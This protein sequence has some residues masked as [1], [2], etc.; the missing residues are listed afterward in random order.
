MWLGK[1]DKIIFEMNHRME[2]RMGYDKN[3]MERV[4]VREEIGVESEHGTALSKIRYITRV[5]DMKGTKTLRNLY[6]Y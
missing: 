1:G 4:R 2:R 6:S 3:R 5:G